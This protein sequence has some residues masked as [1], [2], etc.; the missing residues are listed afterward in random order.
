MEIKNKYITATLWGGLGNQLFIYAASRR[1][2]V[3][4]GLE[5]VLD[6]ISGF[7][8]DKKYKRS[9]QLNNFHIPFYNEKK[10]TR[11][12]KTFSSFDRRINKYINN[13]LPLNYKTYISQKSPDFDNKIL[14]LKPKRNIRIEGYWQSEDYFIDIENTIRDDLKFNNQLNYE[15]IYNEK[16]IRYENSVA[17]HIREPNKNIQDKVI[18]NLEN[19]Y[20][21]AIDIIISKIENPYFFIF[22]DLKNIDYLKKYLKKYRFKEFHDNSA[23]DDLYLM[24]LCRHFIIADSTFSWWGAWLSI[25]KNKIIIAPG[26]TNYKLERYWGFEGLIPKNWL[27]I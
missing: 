11:K 6:D 18:I 14:I 8:K 24:Q 1:L 26:Y 16:L 23:I 2:S 17:L 7:M 21:K 9:N 13:F 10:H 20:I 5:L 12:I 15:N 19:Y 3:M 27:V 25:N 4:N 22:G